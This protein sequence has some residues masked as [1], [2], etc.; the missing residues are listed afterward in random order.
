MPKNP[1]RID[2]R[3]LAALTLPLAIGLLTGQSTQRF[4]AASIRLNAAC[5][6]TLGIGGRGPAAGRLTLKCGNLHPLIQQAFGSGPVHPGREQ[7]S[8][9]PAWVDSDRYEIAAETEGDTPVEQ[10]SG[11]MMRSLLEDRFKLKVHREMKEVPVYELTVA[12]GGAKL[13]AVK[14]G[15]CIPQDQYHPESTP[16]GGPPKT[17]PRVCGGGILGPN[18]M[19]WAGATMADLCLQLS[20]RMDRDVIDKTGLS[21]AFEIHLAMS[22]DDMLPSAIKALMMGGDSAS[23]APSADPPGSS[24][25]D[26]VQKLGRKLESGKHATE[27]LVIDHIEKPSEN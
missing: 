11:P 4:D 20:I 17:L 18:G 19:D 22:P 13:Q 2:R 16:A 6:P 14:A 10:M 5:G 24:L 8:G 26:A 21:G 23:P 12:K 1:R 9:G 3:A 15:S 27:F 25:F 7:V